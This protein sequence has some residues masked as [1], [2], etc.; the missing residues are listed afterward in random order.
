MTD[1]LRVSVALCTF[2][3]A[4]F[5]RQQVESI[6]AQRPGPAQ[7]VVS[8][9]GSRDDTL[10]IVRDVAGS[11]RAAAVEVV[12][13]AGEQPVGVTRNFQRA[14]TAAD[15]DLIALSDQDDVWHEGRLE[16]IAARFADD[17]ALLLVHTDA[18]LVD[19]TG[20]RLGRTLFE[21]LEISPDEFAAEE[22]GRA[23]DAFIRRNLATGATVV[24]RRELLMAALPFPDGW[25]HD[26]WLAAVAAA[27]GRVDV[28]REAT[29]DYRQH[30]SNQIGVAA[31]SLRGKIKRVLE[32]RGSRNTVLAERFATLADRLAGLGDAVAREKL[33][34]AR[35]KAR[36]EA[37]RA[38]F[39]TNRARRAL[40]VLR[41]ASS[42]RYERF[43][44]RGR[45]DV[46]R[47]LLQ[48]A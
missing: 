6:L 24:F 10:E 12:V 46:V 35:E 39:P 34:M 15:G 16:R 4:R 47:D 20:R 30:E 27:T 5:V 36:F 21:S 25:V 33:D 1:G 11:Q 26:E 9:D 43:A 13:L 3:G 40:P 18:D 23:F 32:P 7:L 44:S 42:G 48:P 38:A 45:G 41:L 29:I 8:D 22:S 2:N 17:P 14:V 37:E 19:S 31:P 28:L